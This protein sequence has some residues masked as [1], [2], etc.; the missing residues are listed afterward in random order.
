[1]SQIQDDQGGIDRNVPGKSKHKLTIISESERQKK[2]QESEQ[3]GST[4][5]APIIELLNSMID[6]AIATRGISDIHIRN[7]QFYFRVDGRLW[8]VN[9]NRED[10]DFGDKS[11][12]KIF[13]EVINRIK[14]VSELNIAERRRPQEGIIYAFIEERKDGI[15]EI[16]VPLSEKQAMD[17]IKNGGKIFKDPKT[18]L[19]FP[20]VEDDGETIEIEVQIRVSVIPGIKG[21]S[22]VMRILD[23]RNYLQTLG[24]LG[25]SSPVQDF[26]SKLETDNSRRKMVVAAGPTGSGK[27]TTMYS[28]VNMLIDPSKNLV[29]V[30]DPVECLIQGAHQIPV[31]DFLGLGFAELFEATLRHDPDII[32]VGEMRNLKTAEVAFTAALSGRLVLTTLHADN[33]FLALE[34]LLSL[35][36]DPTQ[37]SYNLRGII[38][39]RLVR[40]RCNHC[41]IKYNPPPYI[42]KKLFRNKHVPFL[43]FYRDNDEGCEECRGVGFQGRMVVSEVLELDDRIGEMLVKKASIKDIE[44]Y[45]KRN[46]MLT[47]RDDSISKLKYTT[48]DEIL[49][50]VPFEKRTA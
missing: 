1:M 15:E 7:E 40:M 48:P 47:M 44:M 35:G 26:A 25:H 39:Q 37:I 8:P 12:E 13:R 30:E 29:T 46:G 17:I 31:R 38:S 19:V 2:F 33:C 20:I 4:N 28:L 34:R 32:L 24:E 16:I 23:P 45:A 41:E 10:F 27:T 18:G 5:I 11:N 21:E 9:F 6:K 43:D 3:P 42:L 49:R 50:C 36:V 14:I 22:I